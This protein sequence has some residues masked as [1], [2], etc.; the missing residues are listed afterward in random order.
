M[1]GLKVIKISYGKNLTKVLRWKGGYLVQELKN[2]PFF[3]ELNEAEISV[4]NEIIQEK[5][6]KKGEI[7]FFQGEAGEALY[8]IKSG[9]VKL[10]K[11]SENGDE[12]ILNILKAGDIFAEVVLFDNAEYPAT[13]IVVEDVVLSILKQSKMERI[14]KE[15]PSIA[16]KIMEVMGQRLRRAQKMVKE[17]GLTDTK[18]RTASILVYL[19]EEHGCKEKRKELEIDLSLTQQDLANMIGTSRETI[20]R[21]LSDFKAK[22]LVDTS[23]QKILI[24]DLVKLKEMF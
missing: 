1:N 24:K 15:F 3:T 14:I 11:M 20:S 10:V 18:T 7:I 2:I 8:L 16:L 9:K 4:I 5:A 21:I 12:Q 23:R 6:Y 19:A 17:L 13:A 22:D